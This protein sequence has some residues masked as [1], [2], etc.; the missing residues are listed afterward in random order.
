M[1]GLVCVPFKLNQ[2]FSS[3][4]DFIRTLI[5]W[6]WAGGLSSL[7]FTRICCLAIEVE[8][9]RHFK[10]WD[11]RI[12]IQKTQEVNKI[13]SLDFAPF[14]QRAQL[15][16]HLCKFLFLKMKA[17]K[18]F[19]LQKPMGSIFLQAQSQRYA[20][21]ACNA[22][23]LRRKSVRQFLWQQTNAFALRWEERRSWKC[24]YVD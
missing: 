10:N 13:P 20:R 6:V 11:L 19:N 23:F 18:M 1:D 9:I 16:I 24:I 7:H 8:N 17:M 14:A 4:E 5:W 2:I 15:C 12:A 3:S 21:H 22:I